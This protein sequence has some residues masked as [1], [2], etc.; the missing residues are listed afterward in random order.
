MNSMIRVL[1]IRGDPAH[2]CIYSMHIA[3]HRSSS[4]YRFLRFMVR[5]LVPHFRFH[6]QLKGDFICAQH[7]RAGVEEGR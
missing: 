2:G 5:L 6:A 3:V 7:L 1:S 4:E